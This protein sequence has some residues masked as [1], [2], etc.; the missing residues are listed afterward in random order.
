MFS[1]EIAS[2]RIFICG[3]VFMSYIDVNTSKN[4][5]NQAEYTDQLYPHRVPP[6]ARNYF[7]S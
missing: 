3:V 5:I 1:D 4:C 2:I 7:F 6:I